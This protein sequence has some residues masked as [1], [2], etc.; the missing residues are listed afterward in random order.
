LSYIFIMSLIYNVFNYM[1]GS[2]KKEPV[3][4]EPVLA[5]EQMVTPPLVLN[6]FYGAQ[7]TTSDAE[8]Y[9]LAN[10][11]AK[12]SLLYTMKT[13]AYIRSGRGERNLGRRLLGWLQKYDEK[14]LIENMPLFLKKYGRYDDFIYL[15]RNS[16]AM[17][18]YL[19]HLGNQLVSDHANMELGKSVSLAA[20]W[21][22]SETSAVNKKTALTFRLARSMKIPISELRKKYLTPLRTY[23]GILEQKMCAKDWENVDYKKV[24]FQAFRRHKKAFERNDREK[25]DAHTVV[26]PCIAPCIAPHEIVAPYLV[27]RPLNDE[28]ESSWKNVNKMDKTVVLSDVSFSTNGITLLISITLGLLAERVLTFEPNPQFVEVEAET[29]YEKVQKMR[30][31]PSSSSINI[32]EA[33]KIMMTDNFGG[34]RLVIVSDMPLN[35]ADSLYNEAT[36]E[37]MEKMFSDAGIKMPQ[38][39]YWNV[40]QNLLTFEE[41]FGITVVSGFS[42]DILQCILNGELPTQFNAMMTVLNNDKYDDIK[43]FYSV[44]KVI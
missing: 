21:V 18:A 38:I 42:P 16:K 29:L 5:T 19:K 37:T 6:F 33:L 8:L 22:P 31:I 14:Q 7:R 23:I 1:F 30:I 40:K 36:R 28:L 17:Y 44:E 43:E 34:K 20:K 10:A 11:A 15:P 25:Y 13:I 24:P 9:S 39:V 32:C 4:Q 3:V 41:M 2:K 27:G 12:E 26:R 35:Q